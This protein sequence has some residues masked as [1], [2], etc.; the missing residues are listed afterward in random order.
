VAG[1]AASVEG[2]YNVTIAIP[3]PAQVAPSYKITAVPVGSQVGD[4]DCAQFTLNTAN[5]QYAQNSGGT[6]NTQTCWGST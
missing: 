2:K 5:T 3:D 6:P 4:T 1:T